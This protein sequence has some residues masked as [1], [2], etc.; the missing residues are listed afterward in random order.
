[1]CPVTKDINRYIAEASRQ[2]N[3]ADWHES[4]LAPL[5]EAVEHFDHRGDQFYRA[6]AIK[7]IRA[8]FEAMIERMEDVE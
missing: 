6:L 4:L 2:Q 7:G 8:R 1:M 5:V 3:L